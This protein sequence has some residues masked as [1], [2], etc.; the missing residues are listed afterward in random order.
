RG[1]PLDTPLVEELSNGA[2]ATILCGRFE[3]V[4][5]RVIEEY[6]VQEVSIG[7]YVLSG[8]EPA[9]LVL[10]DACIRRLSGV[11][12]NESTFFEESFGQN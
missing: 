6:A 10:M 12:G 9:A 8:G 1:K 7:D 11:V 3:G 4:D 2:G 5:E